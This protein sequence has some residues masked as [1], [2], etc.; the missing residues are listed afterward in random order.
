MLTYPIT[1]SVQASMGYVIGLDVYVY[2][3]VCACMR[4]CTCVCVCVRACVRVCTNCN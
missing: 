2:R 3:C 1:P 4:A